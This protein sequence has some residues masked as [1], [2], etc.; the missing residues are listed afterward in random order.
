MKRIILITAGLFMAVFLTGCVKVSNPGNNKDKEEDKPNSKEAVE[1]FINNHWQEYGYSA[2]PTKYIA[3]SFDDGPC[4]TA[5]N[6]GTEALLAKLDELKVK[7]T[8]F[9]IGSNVRSNK[10]AAKAIYQAGHELANHS[11]GYSSLGGA[12]EADITGSLTAASEA[13]KDITGEAPVLFRAPNVNY[14][15]NLTKVCTELGLA[16]IGVSVWSSDWDSN[17]TTEKI[18]TN[19]VDNSFLNSGDG[20]I[21]N[22]HESNTSKGKTLAALP[23]M[24][25]GLREKGFWIM[26]VGELAVIKEKPLQAGVQYDSIR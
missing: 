11:D 16:I 23:D 8:F 3:L 26:T 5:N 24:I 21:I 13:I 19:V 12:A 10:D 17:V 9:V 14:G 4:S 15:A 7:A 2:K 18:I 20:G 1:A 6:G 22:C 25:N